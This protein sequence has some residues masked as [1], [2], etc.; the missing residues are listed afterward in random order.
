MSCVIYERVQPIKHLLKIYNIPI[1]KNRIDHIGSFSYSIQK[2]MSGQQSEQHLAAGCA[3]RESR[4]SNS[5]SMSN[6]FI[7]PN[8]IYSLHTSCALYCWGMTFYLF[9]LNMIFHMYL[10]V[11][12]PLFF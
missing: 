8:S 12:F 4:S 1:T 3:L 7:N 6:S 11:L 10:I 5:S 2:N 9:R